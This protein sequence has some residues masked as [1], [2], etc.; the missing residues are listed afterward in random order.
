M[1]GG[2]VMLTSLL[3]TAD[4]VSIRKS[5]HGI[6]Y[7]IG[8]ISADEVDAI[9]PYLS[10]FNLRVIFSEGTSGRSITDVNVNLYDTE[11]KLVFRLAGAQPQL[12]LNIPAGTYTILASYNGDKQRHKFSIGSDEHKKIILNW[13]NLVDEDAEEAEDAPQ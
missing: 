13:K 6:P 8:G 10:Q 9:R 7:L 2:V 5:A 11:G 3:A 4:S 12:L 1:F